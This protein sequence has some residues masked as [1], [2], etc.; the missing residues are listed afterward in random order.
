MKHLQ[1]F[2][3][4]WLAN[5]V[6]KVPVDCV[7]IST[8]LHGL[9]LYR[10]DDF[11][12]QLFIAAGN[13][14]STNHN[15][16]R[17]DAIQVN[18]GGKQLFTICGITIKNSEVFDS[19]PIPAGVDHRVVFGDTGAAYLSIQRWQG[20]QQSIRTDWVDDVGG[21]TGVTPCGDELYD[22]VNALAFDVSE[23]KEI[24]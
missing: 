19:C 11:Q 24:L 21:I 4:E 8:G 14:A 22:R 10:D 2:A 23:V 15:H 20:E 6:F 3:G 7:D 5:P 9:V 1:Q 16:P 13:H 12:V 18:M 17:C